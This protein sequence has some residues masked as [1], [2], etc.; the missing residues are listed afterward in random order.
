MSYTSD[1]TAVG[2]IGDA[3]VQLIKHPD[4]TWDDFMESVSAPPAS[5]PWIGIRTRRDEL[6]A[7]SDVAVVADKW[8]AMSSDAQA[9]WTAYRQALRDL[10]QNQTDPENI[11]WP[12]SPD[13]LE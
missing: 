13:C 4:Q 12:T 3:K 5:D 8:A 10:P 2:M 11:T 1:N 9:A 7:A 6:L